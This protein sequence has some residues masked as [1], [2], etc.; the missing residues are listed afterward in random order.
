MILTTLSL[1]LSLPAAATPAAMSST[2]EALRSTGVGDSASITTREDASSRAGKTFDQSFTIQT[3]TPVDYV[4]LDGVPRKNPPPVTPEKPAKP[5][6]TAGNPSD[7]TNTD[8]Y[9]EGTKP[10]NG[11]T[12]YTPVKGEGSTSGGESPTAKY[13]AYG[14]YALAGGAALLVAGLALG[15]TPLVALALLG[16]ILIG[17]GAVLSFLFGKK[18]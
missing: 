12:I 13:G 17:A 5:E 14:K 6:D 15:G 4:S 18:K 7:G 3:L 11:I 1:L 9:F 8:Y 16:G 2:L 10:L